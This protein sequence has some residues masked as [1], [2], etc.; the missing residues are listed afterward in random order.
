MRFSRWW[1]LGVL[2]FAAP[3]MAQTCP[4]REGTSVGARSDAARLKFLS[5]E[6]LGESRRMHTWTTAWGLTYGALTIAQIAPVPLIIPQDQIEW[7]IGA[8]TSAFGLAVIALEPIEVQPLEPGGDVC[9][10]IVEGE[11]RME[12]GAVQEGNLR[13][14]YAH[15]LNVALNL[16]LGLILGLGYDHWVA[17]AVNFA[18]GVAAG[19]LTIFTA[20]NRLRSAWAE[21]QR[22][23]LGEQPI[24]FHVF[25]MLHP[26]GAGIGFALSF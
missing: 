17:A 24:A 21:Y 22:G 15:A 19:E 10:L 2:A 11:R 1:L 16:G 18:V 14:W 26:G 13:Q 5:A 12:R 9:A 8:A 25:P 7:W 20:P 3:S 6:L 23:E 4:S